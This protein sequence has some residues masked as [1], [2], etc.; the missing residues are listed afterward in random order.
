MKYA[1]V[2]FAIC[3]AVLPAVDYGQSKVDAPPVRVSGKLIDMTAAAVAYEAV[4][5]RRPY[6]QKVAATAQTD[7]KG[8]FFFPAVLPG[9]YTLTAWPLQC[10]QFSKSIEINGALDVDLGVLQ[11]H[12]T[13]SDV[14]HDC[15]GHW[16][17]DCHTRRGSVSG[18]VVGKNNLPIPNAIVSI[19]GKCGVLRAVATDQDGAFRF[20]RTPNQGVEFGLAVKALGFERTCFGP[21]KLKNGSKDLDV[22]RI[23][24]DA[25][26]PVLRFHLDE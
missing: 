20:V 1:V 15:L 6:P 4:E 12:P 14:D 3:L 10:R 24:L 21:V 7:D 17:F 8:A 22:G 13:D 25:L 9:Q 18:R 2:G 5:L 26:G 11:V 16:D 19:S 23:V